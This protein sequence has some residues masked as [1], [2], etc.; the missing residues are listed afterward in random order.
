MKPLVGIIMGSATDWETMRGAS[1]TLDALGIAYEARVVSAHRTPDLL[2]EYAA[3]AAARG[4]RQAPP[5]GPRRAGAIA[6]TE[7]AGLAPV[8]RADAGRDPGGDV[9]H[10]PTRSHQRG[11]VCRR[12]P[13]GALPANRERA[14]ALSR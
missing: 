9:C 3:G 8:D 7:R 10:R 11:A 12:D 5:A 13:R 2:F 6:R 1:D 14:Q 4:G